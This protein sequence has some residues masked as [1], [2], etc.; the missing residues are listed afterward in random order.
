MFSSE[1]HYFMASFTHTFYKQ[2]NW[3]NGSLHNLWDPGFIFFYIIWS[4]RVCNIIKWVFCGYK[5]RISYAMPWLLIYWYF[6]VSIVQKLIFH[7]ICNELSHFADFI[8]ISVI[9]EM[10]ISYLFQAELEAARSEIQKWHSAF[11]NGPVT[12]AGTSLG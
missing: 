11:Q 9:I 8:F 12:P 10:T 4:Y 6:L 2:L 7:E 1:W 5:K 3:F